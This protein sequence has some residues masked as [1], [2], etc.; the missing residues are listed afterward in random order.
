MPASLVV[1]RKRA[2]PPKMPCAQNGP[3]PSFRHGVKIAPGVPCV[4]LVM[5]V[6]AIAS[7]SRPVTAQSEAAAQHPVELNRKMASR[8][9]VSQVAP[10]YPPIARVNYIR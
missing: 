3:G 6:V 2:V 7:A 4:L 8:L 10:E 5:L 1:W 9:L